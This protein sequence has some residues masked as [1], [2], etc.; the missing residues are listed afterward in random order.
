MGNILFIAEQEGGKLKG[1]SAELASKAHELSGQMGGKAVGCLLGR[2]VAALAEQLGAFGVEQAYALEGEALEPF[3]GDIHAR[4]LSGLIEKIKPQVI[5]ASASTTGK[6]ILPRL[7]AKLK[8]GLATDC[9]DLKIESGKLKARRP[10]FAGKALMDVSFNTDV[11]LATA[12]PNSFPTQEASAGKKAAVEK[13]TPKVHGVRVK[14]KEVKEAEAGMKDLTEAE[15]IVSGGRALGNSENFKYVRELAEVLGATVGAS[16]AAVDAGYISHDHQVGQT[17]KTVN[18]K[19]Y[20]AC[21]ISGAIQHL[22]GMRTS[23]LIVAIN[24]DPEAP[25]FTKCDYGIVGDLFQILPLLTSK[26][27]E[28]LGK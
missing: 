22:A 20:I 4:A 6:D 21:G 2:E 16:R 11:Q 24:K 9:V 12:R 8:A 26:F 23:K 5:L 19:L 27:K 10:I 1:Y 13:I 25:I 17:G 14:V 7:A 18:P 28:L 3:L 15:I